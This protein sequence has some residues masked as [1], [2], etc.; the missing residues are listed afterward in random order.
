MY[1]WLIFV[2][3]IFLQSRPRINDKTVLNINELYE[4]KYN[5]IK[6]FF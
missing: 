2:I 1:F 6:Q 3:E 4:I 5:I